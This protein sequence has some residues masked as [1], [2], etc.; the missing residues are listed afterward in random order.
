MGDAIMSYGGMALLYPDVK[1]LNDEK[2][3][4]DE[5]KEPK[6]D[7]TT[8]TTQKPDDVTTTSTTSSEKVDDSNVVWGD[9]NCDGTVSMADAV[10]VMQSIANPDKYG[11]TGSDKDHITAQGQKNADV[12]GNGN[13]VSSYDALSIQKYMLKLIKELPES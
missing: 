9:A 6:P 8:T 10:L 2:Y 1:P 3:W 11:L 7:D 5:G 4:V 12:N 13:G